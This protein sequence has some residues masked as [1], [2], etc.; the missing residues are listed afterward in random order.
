[1]PKRRDAGPAF[2]NI[3]LSCKLQLKQKVWHRLAPIRTNDSHRAEK[4]GGSPEENSIFVRQLNQLNQKIAM[5]HHSIILGI[6]VA[7]CAT[8][9]DK[10]LGAKKPGRSKY[11]SRIVSY[12]PAP[13]QFINTALGSPEAAQ[14]IVGGRSGCLSL[15]GFGGYVVF[16]FDH[17]VENIAGTDFVIFGNAFSGSS[18]PGI[19]EVS[20]DGEHWYRL[21]G[22]AD[23]EAET[24]HRYTIRY[25]RPTQTATTEAVDWSDNSGATGRLDIISYHGQ[26]YWPAFLSD[27]PESLTF[28]GVRLPGNVSWNEKSKQYVFSAFEWGYTDNWSADYPEIAG[29]DPDTQNSNKF[30]LDWAVDEAGNRVELKAIRQVKVYTALNQTAGSLGETSTEVC[31]ALS[32]SAGR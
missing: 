9:C 23:E 2:F 22:S 16:E 25:D 17:E 13:G 5:K 20:A 12:R 4:R 32:L 31:G 28:S 19:V 18:E 7:L 29:N 6:A 11:I 21:A 14:G 1:M 3:L 10:D 26:S 27:N 30:D 15:G 8:A 24:V